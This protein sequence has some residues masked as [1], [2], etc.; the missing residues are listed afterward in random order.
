M[1]SVK[2]VFICQNCGSQRSKWEGR[3]TDCGQWNTFHEEIID[4]QPSKKGSAIGGGISQIVKSSQAL[5]EVDIIRF[6]SGFVEL[7]RVLGGGIVPGSFVLLGGD[8]GIGKSTLLLQMTGHCAAGKQKVLY[9]SAEESIGQSALRAQRLGIFEDDLEITSE[10]NLDHIM[11]L[12]EKSNPV[13][14][15]IDSIQTVFTPQI[16]SAPGTVSQV[17]ECAAQLMGLA[18]NKN[19]A[20]FLVG[21]V[22]KEG[23]LAGPKVL[24][25]IVDTVLSFE[26]DNNYQYR[27]LRTLKNRFGAAYEL[28]VFEMTSSGLQDVENPSEMFLQDRLGKT[29]IGSA[30]TASVEGT[31][32]VLCEVQA[33]SVRSYTSLPRR[34]SLGVDVNRLFLILAVLDKFVHYDFSRKDV[35]VNVVGGLKIKETAS[36][37]TVCAALISSE[38]GIFLPA[39]SCFFGEVGLTGEIR[40]I[41]FADVRLKEAQKLGFKE[42]YLPKANLK[43]I[44]KEIAS[45][46]KIY[47]LDH[48]SKLKDLLALKKSK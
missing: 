30:V 25:H 18:K 46:V 48:I 10:S 20:V 24:E 31:R 27:L 13:C 6:S 2:T 34:T 43:H 12:V 19:I 36:D 39:K 16:L 23:E 42:F 17:R 44:E 1:T 32:P 22:T 4:K 9:I 21:H 29:S 40:G 41:A 3:C 14:L 35:F 26:G 47:D 15:I 11:R 33:L 5:K 28:G 45:K 38:V 37:L 8:P 7:D